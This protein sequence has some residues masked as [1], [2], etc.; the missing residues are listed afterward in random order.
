MVI[1]IRDLM[2]H[3]VLLEQQGKEEL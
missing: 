3:Q 1:S 2:V